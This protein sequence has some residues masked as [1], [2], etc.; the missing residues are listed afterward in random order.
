MK[1]LVMIQR[2]LSTVILIVKLFYLVC[3]ARRSGRVVRGLLRAF[4]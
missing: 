2:V 4:L 1:R 3:S